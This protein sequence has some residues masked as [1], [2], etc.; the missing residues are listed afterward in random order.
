MVGFWRGDLFGGVGETLGPLGEYA[1]RVNGVN[2]DKS[3]SSILSSTRDP[4]STE[5]FYHRRLRKLPL[6]KAIGKEKLIFGEMERK[7]VRG[8]SGLGFERKRGRKPRKEVQYSK[9]K[10]FI[11]T[12]KF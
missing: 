9:D 12:M 3:F 10:Y 5:I 7:N 2:H 4:L 6:P 11:C 8:R 1:Y